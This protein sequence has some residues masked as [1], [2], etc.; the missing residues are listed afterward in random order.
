M[1][2][3][4][5]SPPLFEALAYAAF[6]VPRRFIELVG[7]LEFPASNEIDVLNAIKSHAQRELFQPFD[8]LK[9]RIP[10]LVKDVELASYLLHLFID[11]LKQENTTRTYR[12]A[13]VAVSKH[14][15]LPYA[16]KKALNLLVYLGV[17]ERQASCKLGH[18]RETADRLLI[19]PALIVSENLLADAIKRK[20]S[21]TEIN[22]R[23]HQLEIDK[24]KEYGRNNKALQEAVSESSS[25]LTKP[26]SQCGTEIPFAAHFCTNC[27]AP[28]NQMSILMQILGLPSSELDLTPGIK[29]KVVEK[30]TTVGA[31]F[32]AADAELDGLRYVGI[33]RVAI[34]RHAVDEL[35]SG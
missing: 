11:D 8:A 32:N 26:C 29:T 28:Q 25:V 17:L 19:N 2:L 3:W 9:A 34:I 31:I 18:T 21:L 10:S 15:A 6:G 30:F 16:L 22:D 7:S 4:D 35:I 13:Y 23:I 20:L 33:T 12:T 5:K 1:G 24:F 14:R 27:G